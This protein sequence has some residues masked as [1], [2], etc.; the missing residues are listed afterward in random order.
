MVGK[1]VSIRSLKKLIEKS[2]INGP[3]WYRAQA[4]PLEP[5]TWKDVY[6]LTLNAYAMALEDVLKA[7]NGNS[8]FLIKTCPADRNRKSGRPLV[9]N[10][11]TFPW[12]KKEE[13][14]S[15]RTPAPHMETIKVQLSEAELFN[16]F[17]VMSKDRAADSEV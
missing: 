9:L 5:P 7:L 8:E 10:P 3:R 2:L 13:A 1:K 6:Q 11:A 16:T 4:D 15:Q 12:R 14:G 17:Q